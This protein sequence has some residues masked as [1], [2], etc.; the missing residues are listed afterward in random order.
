MKKKTTKLSQKILDAL[1]ASDR[2]LKPQEVA[3]VTGINQRS[4]RYALN[5]LHEQG[6]LKKY[7]DMEDLRTHFYYPNRENHPSIPKESVN[8]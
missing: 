8:A 1:L 4:V 3:D 5:I 6:F 2:P 7:P